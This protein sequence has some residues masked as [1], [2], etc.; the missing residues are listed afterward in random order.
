[1]R[2]SERAGHLEREQEGVADREWPG[3]LD[4]LLQVLALDAFEDDV[5]ASL[6][7]AAVDH[8]DDVRMAQLRDR[9]RF[10]TEALDVLLVLREL[11]VEHL[12]RD[13]A[14]EQP[15]VRLPDAR[16]AAPSDQLEQLIT[17]GD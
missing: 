4:Q 17:T 9:A 11:L 1:M 8:R 10:T 13:G 16:H 7:L 14:V 6:V 2:E 12:D 3:P 15:V 5:L